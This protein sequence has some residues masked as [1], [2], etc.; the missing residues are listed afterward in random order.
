MSK[1]LLRWMQ[2]TILLTILAFPV[3]EAY[4]SHSMGAD[5]TYQCL[6][7]NTYRVTVSF[8]RDCIGINAPS[9]PLVTINS[10]SCGQ[11][12]SVTC[13]PRPGTGQEVT[14][15]CSSSV[16][17]CQ[18]GTFTGIQEWV[19]DGIV[20]LPM[21]CSDWVFGYSLCCRNAAITNITTPG[22]ST[23]YIYATLNN[24][25]TPCNNS[26]TFSNKPVPFVCLGQQFCFNHGA[27]DSDG[28]SLVYSLITP[29][30][31]VSTNVNYIAP[32]NAYQPLNS[33]P[34]TSFDAQT[35]DIC[36]TPQALEVTVMAVLVQEYRNG[37]LIGSVERDIQITVMNCANNLPSLSGI[38][39]TNN[40]DITV[41]ANAQTCF[42][43]F[44]SDP[45]A[46]QNLTVTW[47]DAIPGATF[48]TSSGPRPTATFCWTPTSAE[49][50]NSYT[51]TAT[52]RDDACPYYGSQT[53]AY[54][55]H[56]IGI[57]VNAGPDQSIACSDLATL[58]ANASG[59]GPYTYLWNNGSTMQSITVG[60]GTWW[61]TASNGTCT[62]TDTVVVT[63][64]FIPVADFTHSA[65]SCLNTP[66]QFTDQ[67]TTPG[68]IIF[69]WI[70]DFGD[71]S[72]STQQN[73]THQYST[74][75]TYDVSL[76]IENSLGCTDTV[77]Q[78]IVIAPPPVAAFTATSACVNS[79]VS[80]TD[81]TSPAGT[82]W[83]W[84]FG[85]GGSST[86]QNPTHTY[87]SPGTYNVTLVSTSAGGCIDTVVNPV[88][89]FP[90]PAIN[91]GAD[92]TICAGASTTLSASGGTTYTW[93]PGGN[94]GGTITVSPTT[95]TT[96]VV[97][98]TDANGCSISDTIRVSVT[99]LPRIAAG[100]DVAICA[101]NAA[102]LNASGGNSYVWY[103][104]GFTGPTISVD[105]S[106]STSYTVVGTDAFGCTNSDTVDVAV[107]SLPVATIS[108]D[109]DICQGGSA[110]LTAGGGS[111]YTWTPTGSTTGTI[112]V[113]PGSST[114]YNVQVSDGNGC[115]T[116]ASVNVNVHS[117]PPVNLQSSFLCAGS[118]T[119]LDAGPGSVSYYWTPTGD[120]T[121]TLSVSTGGTYAVTLT[122]AWGCTTTA[123][124]TIN[125][126][127][128]ITINLGN[129]SFCQGDS[130]TLDAGYAGMNYQWSTG[131]T[132]QAISVNTP[133]S[134]SV[135]VTDN[136]GCSGSIA[137]T[138]NVN[139]L[140]VVSFSATSAC[141]GSATIFTNTSSIGS[142]SISSYSWNFG[143]GDTTLASNPSET[144]AAAGTYSVSLTATSVNG[145][146]S[147]ITQ[148]VQVNPLPV[149]AFT[150]PGAC[151]GSPTTFTDNSSVSSG[152]I[153]TYAWNFG[154]GNNSN[155]HN[156]VH[157]YSSPGNYT[158]DLTVTT[159]G[160][161][162]SSSTQTVAIHEIPVAGFVANPVCIG[163]PMTFANSS[164]IGAGSITSW[165]WDFNDASTSTQ[166]TPSHTYG[167]P[168]TY[169][170][171]LIAVSNQG[172][173]DTISQAVTVNALPVVSAGADR[174]LCPGGSV[175]LSA[176]GG[177]SYL[178]A[179][180]A[181]TTASITVTPSANTTYTVQVTDANGCSASDQVNVSIYP[182][183]IANAGVDPS[184]CIGATT[185]LTASGG[186]TYQWSPGGQTSA[187][188][189]VQPNTTTQYILTATDGNGCQA[190]DTVRVTVNNL[191]AVNAG[192][193]YS[194]CNGSSIALTASGAQN[195][196]WQPTGTSG[197]TLIVTPGTNS[198]YVVTGTDNNGCQARD[199][200]RV[201]VN[202]IP[203][204]VLYPTFVCAGFSTDLDAGNPGATYMW[205][206]GETTQ[207]ISVSDSGSFSVVVT[208]PFGCSALAATQ[209]TVGGSI[210]GTPTNTA[211]CSGQNTILNAGN[212]GATYLWSTGSTAQSISTGTAG[213]YY[214][215]ITDP[216][217][218]SATIVHNVA[219]NPLPV[220]QFAAP[221]VCAG[222]SLNFTNQST[223][224]SGSI[225]SYAWTFGNGTGSTQQQPTNT[226]TNPGSYTVSLTV[227]SATGCS[228]S[229]SG[230]VTIHPNPQ[231]AFSTTPVCRG[232][233][234]QFADQS[235]VSSGT[236][237]GWTW[238]FG[239]NQT[240]TVAAPGHS[241]S[242]AGTYVATLVVTSNFGCRDTVTSTALVHELP[243][244]AFSTQNACAQSTVP[245]VNNSTSSDGSITGYAWNL[246]DG[247]TSTLASPIHAYAGDG[248]FTAQL[249]VTT[250]YGC[251]D[252]L[253]RTL[254]MY[255]IPE[256][257]FSLPPACAQSGTPITN[258]TTVSSGS[259]AS[260]YWMFGDNAVSSSQQPN[261]AY[262]ADGT[263]TVTLVATSDRG[264]RDTAHQS[265]T[266]FPLPI[267][268]FSAADV[269]QGAETD[270][271]DQSSV[272][273]GSILNWNWTFGDNSSSTLGTPVH[274]YGGAGTY[275]VQL[276]VTTN[277]GC[278]DVFAS[279]VNI[280]P[281]PVAAFTSTNV[282]FG[283]ANQLTNLSYL[284]GGGSVNSSWTFSDGTTSNLANP[285]HTF[286]APGG[287]QV[288][289]TV[290]SQHGCSSTISD[291]MAV[292]VGPEA[293]FST[294]DNC[295]GV[296]TQ[297]TDQ[298]TAQDGTIASW[299]WNFGDGTTSSQ[300]NP[301]HTYT[302]PGQYTV[303]LTTVSTFGCDGDYLDSLEIYRK[304]QPDIMASNV[305]VG[306]PIQFADAGNSQTGGNVSY[307]WN[308][309]NGVILN[310]DSVNF[311]YLTPGNYDVTLTVTSDHGCVGT[312]LLRV[313]VYPNPSVSFT[314]NDV[315]ESSTTLFANTT[316]ITAGSVSQYVWSFGDGQTAVT[317]QASHTYQAAGTYP[318]V[319]T[320]VSNNG[321]MA[322][323]TGTVRVHPN[324]TV[325]LNSGYQGC[326]PLNAMLF[327][328]SAITTGSITGWLWNFG[329]GA[330]S[331]D[332]NPTHLYTGSGSYDITLTVVTD[333]G[334]QA[335][336]MVP[337]L[338][339]VYP[340][341]LADF[342]MNASVLEDIAPTVQFVNQSQGYSAFQWQFGDGTVNTTDINPVHTYRDTGSYT[343][344]L[345]TVNTY[346][347]RDTI[348]KSIEVR[349]VSTLFAPN[350]FTP[351]GDGINEVFK[352]VFTNMENIQV[353][354]FDRWG[355]L[356]TSWDG[357]DGFWD[358]YYEGR[359]CQTDTYVYK[360]KGWGIDG[361]YSEWVGHVSIIY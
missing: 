313:N 141:L 135:I 102:T 7:G 201:T 78:T 155:A 216:N 163:S 292:Y 284:P 358:G 276:T 51:F 113:N 109:V 219:V 302:N 161:C 100:A 260:W 43:I 326:A 215:T 111:T 136:S 188:I 220:A 255:P 12:L 203:T 333:H 360:I 296:T 253:N 28:D 355:K 199:T 269:C 13:Y 101:G 128:S 202:P 170:V 266:I 34:T 48:T 164:T 314:G 79:N 54:T 129:V 130:A 88:T 172:C 212:P 246:G 277:N 36:M 315:C 178:W 47:D 114:T 65:T 288:A 353:W 93:N 281:N 244:A 275:P 116:T 300:R 186:T 193:D 332:R 17:T 190:T 122:D 245:F 343:A 165:S 267:A 104:G 301:S 323:S 37:Q 224:S 76:V 15:A 158:V 68:G 346:G 94:T 156:P 29:K 97:I 72:G 305:C 19:Y 117:L 27:Y 330:V 24:L 10:P 75:G 133:G 183:P 242:N 160:G 361:K 324:P 146:T 351:N 290:T 138:A 124:A 40:F 82:S 221:A 206:T 44:S 325:Q 247:N 272:S 39:G 241:Y 167:T 342:S 89:V 26:P 263:Y 8:Y 174:Q 184:I 58:T 217:G 55:I 218:C 192:P 297:F 139:P 291:L 181:Q 52:V 6:G 207:T 295:F 327:D 347:C 349:P 137:V 278:T 180:G 265:V 86:L 228:A 1:R 195:Y 74:P 289:L 71:G 337:G 226:Y 312:D 169:Q 23:F 344:L 225:A 239:D 33:V 264:C 42:D 69:S 279:N 2:T 85:D 252:T 274:I 38:N 198:T 105:P 175:N 231:A 293:R 20:T 204:V 233:Q 108:P 294:Q 285:S 56:V 154:D 171:S 35:G 280:F 209:V 3:Q 311:T 162:T 189:T 87:A 151:A 306:N 249:V 237:T 131:A 191:P 310:A 115:S 63:M 307:S 321:C 282:C 348:L 236:I 196:Q 211:I 354:V 168:G 304:P 210:S 147:S 339:R 320:A 316:T 229:V 359:K 118:V 123:S 303:T 205:S 32:Y 14:P 84:T 234:T 166:S 152:N 57:S 299:N 182:Q 49:I 92:Q 77:M 345:I 145:C 318:V 238:S 232:N 352:P 91:A 21:Q 271:L 149:A 73:P 357:I 213:L 176:S 18:G 157:S 350:C 16:T 9:A 132:T 98:G 331:T 50:G 248:N 257:Q 64:P 309:G 59:G 5:L 126:G 273:S 107:N 159:A 185:T 4:A 261:H 22:S 194:I 256:A 251:T 110:T 268:Q 46:G 66:I 334:C 11:S 142:G 328:Q 227:T 298:T 177:T 67:S 70:W 90:L 336:R 25:V 340:Q 322:S 341:P 99:A 103:P 95:G 283:G 127:S 356:L 338:I 106:V 134:Y 53:Y 148:P 200:V 197:S 208:S 308:L 222:A 319:L 121:R 150:A 62:A 286:P 173:A 140:P 254:T 235:T 61:V 31:T 317:P 30:Q 81:Q 243:Q 259:I 125:V 329:D 60:A 120:T 187:S 83:N 96:Y 214:V 287:Y 144:Y 153:V 223:V 80:F 240:S 119:T 262:N 250:Q 41:C 270:F 335:S 45:D 112:T 230:P 258:T 143:N 179:P